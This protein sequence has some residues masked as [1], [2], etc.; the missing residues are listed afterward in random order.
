[1]TT[2][3][4]DHERPRGGQSTFDSPLKEMCFVVSLALVLFLEAVLEWWLFVDL[5]NG[6]HAHWMLPWLALVF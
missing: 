2:P 5:E 3:L 1:M 6:Y 4:L